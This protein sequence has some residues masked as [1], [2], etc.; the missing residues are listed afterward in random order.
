MV[1]WTVDG[2]GPDISRT[3]KSS[4]ST[5]KIVVSFSSM[6]FGSLHNTS[7]VILSSTIQIVS[8]DDIQLLILVH[9]L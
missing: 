2:N 9:V 6:H 1:G 5:L 4:N 8:P 7:V 3:Y